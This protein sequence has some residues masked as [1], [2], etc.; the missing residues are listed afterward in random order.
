MKRVKRCILFTFNEVSILCIKS[1]SIDYICEITTVWNDLHFCFRLCMSMCL[2][3]SRSRKFAQSSEIGI[4]VTYLN[5]YTT[6][7]RILLRSTYVQ[8]IW[9]LT[10]IQNILQLD[11][12]KVI[13]EKKTSGFGQME[14][15]Y[16]SSRHEYVLSLHDTIT[17]VKILGWFLCYFSMQSR[18][19]FDYN[20]NE[21]N[22]LVHYFQVFGGVWR[23]YTTSCGH[24][25]P[26]E[27]L[28]MDRPDTDGRLFNGS[29]TGRWADLQTARM[30]WQ[31]LLDRWR[32][33]EGK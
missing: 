33:E 29:K 23:R 4:R 20:D 5:V 32:L 9:L 8:C 19:I 7:G 21:T 26:C 18:G 2:I 22:K 24:L 15:R 10:D 3:L 14:R 11:N 6:R 12:L 17:D 1:F 16:L 31:I 27:S 30:Q 28:R 13:I 25:P